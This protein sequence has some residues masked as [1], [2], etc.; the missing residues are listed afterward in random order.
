MVEI[1]R[2]FRWIF[3]SEMSMIEQHLIFEIFPS[4]LCL[5]GDIRQETNDFF[6]LGNGEIADFY[7]MV[8]VG[9]TELFK[10]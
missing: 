9:F 2:S 7:P 8:L 1:K 3:W 4:N 6:N 10:K 5:L